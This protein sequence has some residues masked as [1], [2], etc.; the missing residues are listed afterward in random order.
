MVGG[1]RWIVATAAALLLVTTASSGIAAQEDGESFDLGISK[2]TCETDPGPLG[3][4]FEVPEDCEPTSGVSFEAANA[5][6]EVLNTCTIAAGSGGCNVQVPYGISVAV[7]EDEDTIPEGYAPREN[8]IT[9]ETQDAPV[10][11][12]APQAIFVNLPTGDDTT[13]ADDTTDDADTGTS[14]PNTGSGTSVSGQ[15]GAGWLAL[16]AAATFG[17]GVAQ[18]L[19][20][21]TAR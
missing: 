6:G 17:V 12:E 3:F 18:R 5:D 11:G 2:F 8:P 16:L 20:R 10:A 15:S 7:T 9:V 14:L 1:W 13:V 19:R 4:G 21:P